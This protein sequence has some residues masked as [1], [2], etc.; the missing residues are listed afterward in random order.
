MATSSGPITPKIEGSDAARITFS[1]S[2]PNPNDPSLIG[3]W[4]AQVI[5][6][7]TVAVNLALLYSGK[8][9]FWAGDFATAPN[10][11]ELWDPATN[12]ITPVPNPYSNIFCS[13]HVALADGRLLVAGGHDAQNGIMGIADANTFDPASETW[14]CP[15]SMSFRRVVPDAH[16][17]W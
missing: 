14:T 16:S 4:S 1:V 7:P 9:I 13:S 17:P 6:L 15:A 3:E 11:G 2:V 10:Y 8:T 12:F 5:D